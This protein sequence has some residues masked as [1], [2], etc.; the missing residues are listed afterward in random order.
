MCFGTGQVEMDAKTM[1]IRQILMDAA[2]DWSVT[3]G[4][5]IGRGRS[6]NTVEA[7]RHVARQLR[8][9]GLGLKQ[10]GHWLG[11]RDHATVINLLNGSGW[12]HKKK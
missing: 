10:I 12:S 11:G 5:L 4:E 2:A 9:M 8:E 7:R 6:R 1:H 3:E